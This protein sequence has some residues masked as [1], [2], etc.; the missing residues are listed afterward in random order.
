V[1]GPA[2]PSMDDLHAR[3]AAIETDLDAG[4]YRPGPWERFLRQLR[5]R[6]RD[7]RS[8]LASDVSRVSEK[9]HRRQARRTMGVRAAVALELAATAAG[10]V[11]LWVGIR[12][13]SNLAALTAAA[14][15][16]TTFQPLCKLGA[17]ALLGVRYAH[18]Y[19]WGVEPRFKMHYGT[20]IAA[21][22][23]ARIG[24]HLSGTVGSPLALWIV[25]ELTGSRLPLASTLCAAAFW[26][27]VGINVI[28]FL[29]ALCGLRRLGRLSLALTSSGAAAAE[30]REAFTGG[31][32]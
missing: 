25:S 15:W 6:P 19:V 26:V 31:S 8:A 11:L 27:V 17:G 23:S 3:L 22:R 10:A 9:L 32:A 21:S 24:L 30:L 4:C 13:G 5:N 1:T 29:G 7:E 18:A 2:D 14:I 12:A 16:M 20:Y 28:P